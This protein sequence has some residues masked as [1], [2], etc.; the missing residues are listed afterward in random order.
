MNEVVRPKNRSRKLRSRSGP[1][2]L[3]S[4]EITARYSPTRQTRFRDGAEGTRTPAL[5][6][7]SQSLSQLSYGPMLP[8]ECSFEIEAATLGNR[9]IDLNPKL[10]HGKLDGELR[11]RAVLIRC[12]AR[13][14]T[15]SAGLGGA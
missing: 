1:S 3:R 15:G 11:D 5:L 6:A 7:A 2:L 8:S 4:I 14:L 9:S 12:H 13:Q 10:H